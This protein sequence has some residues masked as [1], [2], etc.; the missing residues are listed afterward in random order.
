M[1]NIQKIPQDKSNQVSIYI[2]I[3]ICQLQKYESLNLTILIEN[4]NKTEENIPCSILEEN[5]SE[6]V[7]NC[8]FDQKYINATKIELKNYDYFLYHKIHNIP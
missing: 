8:S 5:N 3:N 6:M 1:E 7:Y 4:Q 2:C